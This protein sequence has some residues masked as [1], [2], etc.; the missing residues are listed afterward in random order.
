MCL[1]LLQHK[2]SI[3]NKICYTVFSYSRLL[4]FGML[5]SPF[6][7]L[8]VDGRKNIFFYEI[9]SEPKDDALRVEFKNKKREV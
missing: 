9:L 6:V 3:S 4:E 8:P 7:Y 5:S 2:D 1:K